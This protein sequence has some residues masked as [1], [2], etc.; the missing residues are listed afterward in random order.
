MLLILNNTHDALPIFRACCCSQLPTI[1]VIVHSLLGFIFLDNGGEA[2]EAQYYLHSIFEIQ[3]W[4]NQRLPPQP[5][6]PPT[7]LPP[8]VVALAQHNEQSPSTRIN[9]NTSKIIY[10]PIS[11]PSKNESRSTHPTTLSYPSPF[12][13]TPRPLQTSTRQPTKLL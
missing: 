3:Q 7:S 8:K 10:I 9:T 6:L 13:N 12:K 5:L 11:L 2:P 1:V 4:P